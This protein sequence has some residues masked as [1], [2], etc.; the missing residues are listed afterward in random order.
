MSETSG[1]RVGR[2]AELRA[3]RRK[4]RRRIVVAA[5]VAVAVL[6]A[7]IV[8]LIVK[9]GGNAGGH[10]ATA[11]R[12]QKTLLL[13]VKAADGTAVS[14]ALLADDRKTGNGAI[15]LLQPQVL[16]NA[17]CAGGGGSLGSTLASGGVTAARNALSDVM[18]VTIDGSWVLDGATFARLVDSLGGV[19][20]DVDVPVLSGR[21][22]VVNSGQQ[23]LTGAN[24]LAFATYHAAGEQEQVRL[25][26]LQAVLDAILGELPA[27]TTS[28]V[29]S[30]GSG[31]TTTVPAATVAGV[32]QG[33]AKDDKGDNLQ[34]QSLPVSKVDV[35]DQQRFRIDTAATYQLVDSLLAPS[36]PAG[37]R[38]T[39]NRVLVL[40]GVGTPGLA[41]KVRD[42]LVP[43]G[44]TC[45]G[46]RNADH[47]GYAKSSV[48]VPN[49]TEQAIT[50]GNAVAKAIGVPASAVQ[51]SDQIGTIADVVVIVGADFRPK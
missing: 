44:F 1:S 4:Q 30:L 29:G 36:I 10:K 39:G 23:R 46:S 18:G 49:A 16:V 27:D 42:R 41:N 20:V 50:A 13:Q 34:Y 25:T 24:A 32:L 22:I 6:L 38:K 26:R 3:Q 35:D 33:L 37:A 14:S 7:A 47:F 51:T 9:N 43:A 40:N 11:T 8:F 21:T 31:S 28:L 2:R 12:T 15:V 48:L 45:V 5:V 17:S 19:N